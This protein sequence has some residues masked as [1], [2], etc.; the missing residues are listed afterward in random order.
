MG[1]GVT[2]ER[3]AE[4][5][6]MIGYAEVHLVTDVPPTSGADDH[7][8]VAEE[9]PHRAQELLMDAA[10]LAVLPAYVGYAAPRREGLRAMTRLL[11]EQVPETRV[12]ALAVPAGVDIG[13]ERPSEVAISVAAELVAVRNG[14]PIPRV[15]GSGR[16]TN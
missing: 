6:G 9:N 16:G 10:R 2:A 8:V 4:L 12:L 14:R 11:G 1:G 15:D 3:L 13:A 7:L 5:G